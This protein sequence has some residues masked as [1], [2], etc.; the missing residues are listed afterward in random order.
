MAG[1]VIGEDSQNA[2]IGASGTP[3]AS[4]PAIKGNTVTPQT[5]VM[6]PISD[7]ATTVRSVLPSNA[8]AM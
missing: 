8:P 1:S 7:A 2:M 4:N 5:G 6:A 3:A